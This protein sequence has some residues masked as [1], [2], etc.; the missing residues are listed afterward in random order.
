MDLSS[1]KPA[2]GAKKRRKRVGYGPGSGHGKTATRGTKGQKARS[3]G[4]KE[5]GFEGGQMPLKRRIPKRGFKNP[6]RI[7]YQVL[8]LNT[9]NKFPSHTEVNPQ[10]L[11]QKGLIKKREL[12]KILGEGELLAPLTV[13]AHAFSRSAKEKI[14]AMGGSAKIIETGKG[15]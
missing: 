8:N 7:E 3:G 2:R 14:E 4:V 9:L 12:V 1:L 11:R 10:M 6:F 13:N 5:P 15:E